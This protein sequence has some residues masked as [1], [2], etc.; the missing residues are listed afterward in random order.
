MSMR[1]SRSTYADWLH[2]KEQEA[3][4]ARYEKEMSERQKTLQSQAKRE[5]SAAAYQKWVSQ[6]E[7]FERAVQLMEKLGD[8]RCKDEDKWFEVAVALSAVDMARGV[9]KRAPYKGFP[10]DR[11]PAHNITAEEARK[12]RTLEQVFYRWCRRPLDGKEFNDVTI[13]PEQ[14]EL[15]TAAAQNMMS[16]YAEEALRRKGEFVQS[17]LKYTPPKV[18]QKAHDKRNLYN[19]DTARYNAIFSKMCRS[20]YRRA[21]REALK[22]L[23]EATA[24]SKTKSL[25][26]AEEK[27]LYRL[28]I[29]SS[30]WSRKT[31]S[32]ARSP[33]SEKWRIRGLYGSQRIREE[34]DRMRIRLPRELIEDH[35]K[36]KR[37]PAVQALAWTL[38]A[39]VAASC[40]ASSARRPYRVLIWRRSTVAW[41][42]RRTFLR[43]ANSTWRS[44]DKR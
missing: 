18:S 28:G 29:S 34:K 22:R 31:R 40:D 11:N 27:C 13:P 17:S 37:R 8:D 42:Q 6:K 44:R 9:Y 33:R 5:K 43:T 35:G 36:G 38:R 19:P 32:N 25:A 15:F 30:G 10:L 23:D 4:N 26:A 16:E 7:S 41:A 24:K 1:S 12:V 3:A 20:A 14:A 2:N 39:R 21:Q